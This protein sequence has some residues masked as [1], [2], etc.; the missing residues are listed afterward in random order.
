[1]LRS[2][3]KSLTTIIIPFYW[4]PFMFLS[5]CCMFYWSCLNLTTLWS[6]CYYLCFIN[7]KRDLERSSNLPEVTQLVSTGAWIHTWWCVSPRPVHCFPHQGA[8]RHCPVCPSISLN[9][10][11]YSTPVPLIGKEILSLSSGQLSLGTHVCMCVP[12]HFLVFFLCTLLLLPTRT[13]FLSP[14][15]CV[16]NLTECGPW[17]PPTR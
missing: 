15:G 3:S 1:M 6:S 14:R 17:R 9:G 2:V 8:S 10:A 4:L 7:E 16:L 11:F 5:L 12:G 13:K